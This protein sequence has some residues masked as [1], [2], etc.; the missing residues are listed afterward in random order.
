[1]R[2]WRKGGGGEEEVEHAEQYSTTLKMLLRKWQRY[3]VKMRLFSFVC[4]KRWRCIF[5]LFFIRLAIQSSWNALRGNFRMLHEHDKNQQ[6]SDT[7]TIQTHDWDSRFCTSCIA[8]T[9]SWSLMRKFIRI[10]KR[11]EKCFEILVEHCGMKMKWRQTS[12]STMYQR[13]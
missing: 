5:A 11:K 13:V 4:V 10:A 7:Y 2:R 1:M 12:S 8:S 6:F 9:Y 3:C